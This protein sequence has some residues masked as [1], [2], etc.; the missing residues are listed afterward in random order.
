M[1]KQKQAEQLKEWEDDLQ[2]TKDQKKRLEVN[3]QKRK[4]QF[5]RDGAEKEE[6][7]EGKSPGMAKQLRDLETELE[8]EREQEMAEQLKE[9]ERNL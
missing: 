2:Q 8:E 7:R 9:L 6:V 4:T 5:D 1:R 3:R